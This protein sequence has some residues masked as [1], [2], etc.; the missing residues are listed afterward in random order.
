M[1]FGVLTL[2]FW[3]VNEPLEARYRALS[4][5]LKRLRP[6]FIC[7]QEVDRD[8]KSGRS[9]SELIAEMCEFK[10]RVDE[11]GLAIISSNPLIRSHVVALPEFEGD[12]PRRVL[13]AE[14]LIEQRPVFII[15][16]HLAYPPK[17]VQERREQVEALLSIIKHRTSGHVPK[18]LCGDFNDSPN[19]PAVQTVLRSEERFCDIFATCHPNRV[20]FTYSRQTNRYVE[21]SWTTEQRI[22]YIFATT[23]LGLQDC[24]IVF[25]GDNGFDLVSDHFG[26]FAKLAFADRF[27]R[28]NRA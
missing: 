5:G 2:N 6:D 17:M 23:N 13:L 27:A 26:V 22:D 4:T 15:T 21:P 3:N 16:T 8:P 24:S 9:Q 20:G 14:C 25:N 19:S 10:H 1:S 11:R 12:F 7:L 28:R 18:I